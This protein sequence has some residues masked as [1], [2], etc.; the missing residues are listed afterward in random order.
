MGSAGRA[1]RLRRPRLRVTGARRAWQVW[2]LPGWLRAYVIAV[3]IVDLIAVVVAALASIP[4]VRVA[5]LLLFAALVGCDALTVE[6]TRSQGETAGLIKDI[7]GIWELPVA[8]LLPPVFALLVP[9]PRIVLTQWRIRQI[10]PHRR[11]FTAGAIGLSYGAAYLAFRLVAGHLAGMASI[12]AGSGG[13]VTLR[14]ILAAVLA[15][16]VAWAVNNLLMLPAVKGSDPTVRARDVIGTREG[17]V[18]DTAE[19]CAAVLA[20]V[21]IFSCPFSVVLALPLVIVLQRSSLHAQLL[22][23]SRLDAKTGL[24]NAG[25]WRREASAEVTRASR[26]RAPVAVAL[27]DLDYLKAFNDV[28]GHLAGDKALVM[29]AGVLRT[30]LRE[31][32]IV[33]RFGGDEFAVLFPQTDAAQARPIA[34]RL[35]TQ[36][37]RSAIDPGTAASG[38]R[39]VR[40]TVSVGL[41]ALTGEAASLT[42]ILVLAD[43][44]LY[45][46]KNAGRDRVAMLTDG[47]QAVP[48]SEPD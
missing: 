43:S 28:H 46:A 15:G 34:E 44:A 1:V 19:L 31:Y 42:D 48:A 40:C 16:L 26:T 9:I 17:I 6:V 39:L 47:G 25:T 45:R 11:V 4:G 10:A 13:Q 27:I 38:G 36:I 5:Q 30:L 8:I 14:W 12:S 32:D 35:R 3:V 18:N 2:E 7:Y 29:V 22:S 20:A 41:A 23:D 37:A 33:G 21:A 24:L